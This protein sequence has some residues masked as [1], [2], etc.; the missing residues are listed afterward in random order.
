MATNT[1][2]IRKTDSIFEEIEKTNDRIMRRAYDIFAGNGIFGKDL[3][4]WL[5][6]ERELLWKPSIELREKDDEFIVEVAVPGVDPKDLEI[7]VTADDV[8]VKGDVQ[9]KHNEE[10][11]KVHTC[12]FQSGSLFRAI[13]FPKKINPEKVKAQFNNGV[14]TLSAQIAEE[15]H[16]KKVKIEAA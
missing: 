3:D 8:L 10:A 14:L 11:E 9:H 15:Q 16:A 2:P 1:L 5:A 4:N 13:H 12:E 7:E 6:A